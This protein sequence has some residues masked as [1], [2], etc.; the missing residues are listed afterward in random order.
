MDELSKSNIQL[1]EKEAQ[2]NETKDKIAEVKT[3][4]SKPISEG[5]MRDLLTD[6]NGISFHRFQM[7]VWTFVLGLIFVVE[8]FK[9]LRMPEFSPSY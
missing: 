7:L 3:A 1:A 5:F 6:A 2:L 9:T 4:L 8:V